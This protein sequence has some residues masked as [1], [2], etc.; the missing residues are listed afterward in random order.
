MNPSKAGIVMMRPMRIHLL[1]PHLS[2]RLPIPRLNATFVNPAT[3]RMDPHEY[4]ERPM[5]SIA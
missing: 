5:T 3:R 2:T 4:S 1:A